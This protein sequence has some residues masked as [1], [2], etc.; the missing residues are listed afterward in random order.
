MVARIL[1]VEDN[2]VQSHLMEMYLRDQYEVVVVN[3]GELCLETVR[4]EAFDLLLLDVSLPGINGYEVCKAIKEDLEIGRLPVIFLS[5]NTEQENRIRG[6]EAGAFDYLNKPVARTELVA[7]ITALIQYEEEK[8]SLQQSASFATTT[9]MTAM[10]SASEQG[11]V[12]Q[13]MERS[14]NCH[15]PAELAKAIAETCRQFGLDML[16]QLRQRDGTAHSSSSNGPCSPMEES[17]LSHLSHGTRITDL[18]ARTAIFYDQVTLIL[19]NMPRSDAD[20]YGRLK[21]NLVTMAEGI[22]ARMLALDDELQLN[23]KLTGQARNASENGKLLLQLIRQALELGR[24]SHLVTERLAS[25]LHDSVSLLELTPH[26]EEHLEALVGD[27]TVSL[28]G[29]QTRSDALHEE[30][31]RLAKRISAGN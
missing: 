24:E 21:D 16:V 2:P 8:R 20:R 3:S 17:I 10:S 18:G 4:Q 27:T 19:M 23:E 13:F 25:S 6:F 31:Q 29:I 12:L 26:Q 14:F 11:L 1:V 15:S 30:I 9:A 28:H 22:N 5:A 7:K